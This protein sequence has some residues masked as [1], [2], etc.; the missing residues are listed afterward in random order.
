MRQQL[1][2][3]EAHARPL[4][5]TVHLRVQFEVGRMLDVELAS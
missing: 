1:L 4:L 2:S 3:N 5:P